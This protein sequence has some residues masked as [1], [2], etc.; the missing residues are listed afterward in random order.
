[1]RL[2]LVVLVLASAAAAAA[3]AR[4][5]HE[6]PGCRWSLPDKATHEQVLEEDARLDKCQRDFMG[7]VPIEEQA[8]TGDSVVRA[9]VIRGER[10]LPLFIEYVSAQD[11]RAWLDVRTLSDE[12]PRIVDPISNEEFQIVHSRWDAR[13]RTVEADKA[14]YDL[15]NKLPVP[16]GVV[17]TVCIGGRGATVEVANAGRAERAELDPCYPS[18]WQFVDFLYAQALKDA[19]DCAERTR[20][21]GGSDDEELMRCLFDEGARTRNPSR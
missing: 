17:E 5:E 8:A 21:G 10:A 19:G 3:P 18:E 6:L 9:Y 20:G 7:V 12:K 1:M 14:K 11:G 15:E 2:T 4:A 16:P 13:N